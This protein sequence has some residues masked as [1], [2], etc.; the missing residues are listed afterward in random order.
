MGGAGAAHAGAA[1]PD[2]KAARTNGSARRRGIIEDRSAKYLVKET[3]G[4]A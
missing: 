1:V 2:T 4:M 3:S